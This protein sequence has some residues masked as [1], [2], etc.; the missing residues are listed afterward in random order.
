MKYLIIG[1]GYYFLEEQQTVVQAVAFPD[2]AAEICG[3]CR[4]LIPHRS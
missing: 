4:F 3:R 2:P 1:V